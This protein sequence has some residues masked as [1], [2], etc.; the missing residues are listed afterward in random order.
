MKGFTIGPQIE[1]LSIPAWKGYPLDGVPVGEK[2]KPNTKKEG[3]T[4]PSFFVLVDGFL[5]QEHKTASCFCFD[6]SRQ[7]EAL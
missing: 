7:W 3:D 1:R 5:K 4:T 6:P 2:G